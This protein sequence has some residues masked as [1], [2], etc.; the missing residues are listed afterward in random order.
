MKKKAQIQIADIQKL[1]FDKC[2]EGLS[3]SSIK[4]IFNLLGEFF[5]YVFA[6]REIN[7]NPMD[8]VK[9]PHASNFLYQSK[10]MEILTVDEMKKVISV[11]ERI[12]KNGQPKYRY[13]EAVILLLNTGLRSGELRGINIK[14]IDFERR[15]LHVQQNVV[16]VKDRENGGI[17]YL[18]DGVKTKKS[19]REIPLND[20]AVLALKR[21]LST[22]Y[23]CK[24][25]YLVCTTADKIVT[26]S[27]LQRGYS[28]ILKEAGIEHMGLHSTRH[29]FATVVLKDAEDKGQIKEVS[30]LL[31]H[32]QVSTT[33]TYYIKASD[34]DKR[35]LL[36][37][38]NTLV[39][40]VG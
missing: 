1:L 15:V 12:K 21:M 29:T 36:D 16:Y 34:E 11:A 30:E 32:S 13:G 28:A 33:Y 5:R 7:Y 31:G 35:C 23:N 4:K 8:L 22:T 37:Q 2:K 9:M 17:Q 27:N 6:I 14:D 20:R 10:E 3:E 19:D 38:L 24:T 25:G 39:S 40:D 26:H 18:I